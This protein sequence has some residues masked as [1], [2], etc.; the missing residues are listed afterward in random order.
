M[1]LLS[2]YK[3]VELL[4]RKVIVNGDIECVNSAS[5]DLRLGRKVLIEQQIRSTISLR[6]RDPLKVKEH[7]LITDGPVTLYPGNFCLA[8]THET[9]DLPNTISAEYKLKSSMARIGLEHLNAG[10][11]DAGWNG[12]SLTLEFKNM[13]QNHNIVLN[14]MD[15]I[16]QMVFFTHIEVPHDKSYA[17]RG[18]YNGDKSVSGAKM[19]ASRTI[20]FGDEYEDLFAKDFPVKININPRTTLDLDNEDEEGDSK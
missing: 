13:T 19:Q 6:E 17:S 1:S 4:Q 11:C 15:K 16:G 3:I 12:S 2:Y 10:W 18:R 5:I 7:D 9:F 14:Y 20:N 8:H